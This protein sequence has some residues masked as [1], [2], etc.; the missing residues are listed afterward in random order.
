MFRR[1]NG[2]GG[3][4]CLPVFGT[5]VIIIIMLCSF[6]L[7]RWLPGSP[8]APE[9]GDGDASGA[10]CSAVSHTGPPGSLE[11]SEEGI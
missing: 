11:L 2:G 5:H 10:L 6:L 1:V 3:V 4:Q 7:F 9:L 8:S